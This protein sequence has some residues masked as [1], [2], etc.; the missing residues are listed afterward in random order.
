MNWMSDL[1][2]EAQAT[3]P[4]GSMLSEADASL[5]AEAVQP[6]LRVLRRYV[7][8]LA[9]QL[10]GL[11]PKVVHAYDILGYVKLTELRQGRYHVDAETAD[12]VIQKVVLRCECVGNKPMQFWMENRDE[13]NSLKERLFEHR[14]SF[15]FKDDA[16]WRYVFT[17]NPLIKVEFEFSPHPTETGIRMLS[18]NF[19]RLGVNTYSFPAER[20]DQE[21][22]DEFGKMLVQQ[23]N[24]F[25][26]VSGYRVDQDIR[27]QLQAKIAARRKRREA[28][29]ESGTPAK[30]VGA[31]GRLFKKDET[32]AGPTPDKATEKAVE[33]AIVPRGK[34]WRGSA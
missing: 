13:C 24:R 25:D 11:K 1:K 30:R 21:L 10:N 8:E 26:E 5:T 4:G 7:S 9:E 28:E 15:R 3:H 29:L 23:P 16:H 32:A 18:R 20:V 2:Q 34:N 22:L 19:E 6:Q 27:K 31:L 33:P 12:G 14:V 17:V